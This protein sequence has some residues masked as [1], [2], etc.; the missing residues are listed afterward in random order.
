MSRGAGGDGGQGPT[1]EHWASWHERCALGLCAPE[2]QAALRRFAH[3]RYYR[4]ADVYAQST[5]GLTA[6][7]TTPE[8]AAAWHWFETYL[9]LHNTRAGKSYK[10]WLFARTEAESGPTLD[11]VQGGATL[12]M[13][14]VVRERLRQE[15]S[16]RWVVSLEGP[17]GADRGDGAPSLEELL[18]GP[19]DTRADVELR[20]LETLAAADAA[21]A[22]AALS[23]RERVALLA[24]ELG[25]PLSHPVVTTAAGCGKSM[26][27][28]AYHAALERVAEC[29]QARHPREDRATLADLTIRTF[30]RV[31]ERVVEWG[32]SE[33]ACARFFSTV[34]DD[35]GGGRNW[36]PARKLVAAADQGRPFLDTADMAGPGTKSGRAFSR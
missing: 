24:R 19:L 10:Q 26:L 33:T 21:A 36:Q 20:D 9:Q 32:K 27:A 1:F 23:R 16:A 4:F 11:S 6:A 25:L 8:P 17:A 15:V 13:R 29:T 30:E 31:K 28:T 5:A 3:I 7:A 35:A 34:E 18:P 2:V 22:G 14:D 12:L